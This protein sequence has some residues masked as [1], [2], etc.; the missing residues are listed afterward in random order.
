MEKPDVDSIDGLS[1]AVAIEQK[2]PTKTSRST[3]GTA[4]EIYDYLRLL[5]ARIGRTFC[6]VCGRELKPDTVQSVVDAVLALPAGTRF[7]VAFPLQ[8]SSKVTHDVGDREPA[9]AGLPARE[10]RRRASCISTT[11]ETEASTSRGRR[12]ARRRRSTDRFARGGGTRRGRGRDGVPRGRRRLRDPARRNRSWRRSTAPAFDRFCAS[13]SASSALT[14]APARPRPRRSCSRST[15]RAAHAPR[16]TASAPCSNTTRRSIVPYPDRSLRD[17]A[18]DPWTKPRYDGK[19][20]ALAEFAKRE[21]I[22]MDV[23]VAEADAGAARCLAAR[24]QSRGY[25]GILPFLTRPRGEALQAVH[26][27]VPAAVSDGAGMPDVP[28]HEAQ[29]GSAAGPHR[30]AHDRARSPS[31]PST[32]CIAWLDD[33]DADARSSSRSPRTS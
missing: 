31:C 21:G 10:R 13:P 6:P 7:C 15:T 18:I 8:L 14:T 25:K 22:P 32:S 4:T 29:A 2:N 33:A 28:R 3:V 27:R 12:A 9:R 17:G 24:T 19:R 26:P 30:R 1:P 20:R 11:V 16:A 5:W 23:A